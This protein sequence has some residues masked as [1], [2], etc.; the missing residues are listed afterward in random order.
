[1]SRKWIVRIF[2]LLAS[3][4]I[5]LIIL[6]NQ[7]YKIIILAIL[8]SVFCLLAGLFD[9]QEAVFL[10]KKLKESND[11]SYKRRSYCIYFDDKVTIYGYFINRIKRVL[12]SDDL[13]N[14][15]LKLKIEDN[16]KILN[17][18]LERLRKIYEEIYGE[19]IAWKKS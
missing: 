15:D 6:D 12:K 14:N 4:C 3:L 9:N 10:E 18:D 16:I 1:M 8:G 13:T 17:E 19:D 2:S 11:I 5:T 7:T